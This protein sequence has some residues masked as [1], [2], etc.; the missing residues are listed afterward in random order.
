MTKAVAPGEAVITAW[1]RLVRVPQAVLAAVEADLKAAG[2]PPLSWYDALLELARTRTGL[3]HFELERHMLLAQYN[4]SRLVER[5]EKA[6]YIE[7]QPCPEDGRGQVLRITPSGRALLK[8]MWPV[9]GAAIARHVG[10]RL[11]Q[12]E[13]RQLAELLGRL[14]G[15]EQTTRT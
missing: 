5:L 4:L 2:L 1:A 13:A 6:G 10:S 15:P 7:R 8:R 3:R 11:T 14:Q 12:A 9:Y